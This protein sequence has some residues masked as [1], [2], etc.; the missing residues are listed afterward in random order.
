MS[1]EELRRRAV[2]ALSTERD[3]YASRALN[4]RFRQST[5][6]QVFCPAITAEEIAMMTLENASVVRSLTHAIS[7]I[8]ESYRLMFQP[9][10]EKVPEQKRKE[11]Y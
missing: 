7:V 10:D 9:D 3:E 2:E 5:M 4:I 8:N 1:A 6:G 11:T